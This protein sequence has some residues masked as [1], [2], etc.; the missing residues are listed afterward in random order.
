MKKYM[1]TAID[2]LKYVKSKREQSNPNAGFIVQLIK[3]QASLK[4]PHAK[5]EDHKAEE[6]NA[7]VSHATKHETKHDEETIVSTTPSITIRNEHGNAIQPPN[8]STDNQNQNHNHNHHDH[9]SSHKKSD[10]RTLDDS[11]IE[12]DQIAKLSI[13]SKALKSWDKGKRPSIFTA[14]E[15]LKRLKT[16]GRPHHHNREDS[17]GGHASSNSISFSE[18]KANEIS[19]S[20]RLQDNNSN[21]FIEDP[22]PSLTSLPTPSPAVDLPILPE[23]E[24]E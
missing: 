8:K 23:I 1:M 2:A 6:Y 24:T 7:D 4:I 21:Q 13:N 17:T 18:D 9:N 12:T 11:S 20:L 22:S 15:K 5:N 3:Y 10:T 14:I 16:S 19:I